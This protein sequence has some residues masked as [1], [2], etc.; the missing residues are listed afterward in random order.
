MR[1]NRLTSTLINIGQLL[2]VN[3]TNAY[4]EI[5]KET[6]TFAT[7][8]E[9]VNYLGQYATEI[10]NDYNLY[11]S[12]M[13]A[14]ASLETAYGPASSAPSATISSESKR[15][16]RRQFDC[17]AHMGR[18]ATGRSSGSMRSSDCTLPITNR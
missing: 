16:I 9:F 13:V 11:A 7:T 3:G 14:Q 2:S 10:G 18:K 17:D 4:A 1:W 8:A 6:R 12:V 15:F 5:D